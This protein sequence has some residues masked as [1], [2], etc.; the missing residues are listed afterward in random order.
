MIDLRNEADWAAGHV[1]G[2][3]RVNPARVGSHSIG[4]ADTVIVVD[5]TGS[6][7]KRAAKKLAKEGYRVY[8]LDGGLR[9]WERAG[10]PLRS[11][12]GGRSN[13]S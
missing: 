12:N 4:R 10:L 9:A 6:R 11:S 7:S 2:S 1:E 3:D 13:L 8:H 5:L